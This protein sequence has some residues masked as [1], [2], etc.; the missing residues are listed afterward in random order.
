MRR[1]DIVKLLTLVVAV[2]LLTVVL[3]A[4]IATL[5]TE[6]LTHI[7]WLVDSLP[8]RLTWIVLAVL[9]FALTIALGDRSHLPAQESKPARSC[10]YTEVERMTK[11][12]ELSNHSVWARD[13]LARRLCDT[14]AGLQALREGV[15][16]SQAREEILAGHWPADGSVSEVLQP[17]H[18][19]TGGHY[20]D[21]LARALDS[22]EQYA[23]EGEL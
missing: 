13:V 12:I 1:A 19:N 9:G 18:K 3:H 15:L 22:L 5:V 4:P 21:E 23:R 2:V 11:L 14:A 7:W 20:A 10:P 16:R 17:Q 6:P 8:Q